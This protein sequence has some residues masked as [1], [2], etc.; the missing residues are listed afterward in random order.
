MPK[1]DL[2]L[3]AEDD[4]KARTIAQNDKVPLRFYKD[5][6][7]SSIW[8]ISAFVAGGVGIAFLIS[9]RVTPT[10]LTTTTIMV[11]KASLEQT[12]DYDIVMIG[13]NLARNY[14]DMITSGD[15]LDQVR[16]LLDSDISSGEL[17]ESI[18]ANHIANTQLIEISVMYS[19]PELTVEIAD[20]LVNVFS[21]QIEK[22]Q[23]EAAASQDNEVK[24]QLQDMEN[25][26]A[27]LQEKL[28]EQSLQLYN[29]RLDSINATLKDLRNQIE[30][31][32]QE[33]AP[34]QTKYALTESERVELLNKET[35]KGEL[36]ALQSRYQNE[37]VT[38]TMQGPTFDSTD[39][40]SSQDYA[41]L[42]RN[43]RTYLSLLQNYQNM[44]VTRIPNMVKVIQVDRPILPERPIRPKLMVNLML[45]F[46][47]GSLLSAIYIFIIKLNK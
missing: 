5:L 1:G 24:I 47:A 32:N 38:L 46:V 21:S 19:D 8:I 44:K 27:R 2:N 17:R 37:L 29:Q 10:Y 39:L 31:I 3:H 20:S 12:S 26:I 18:T 41:L 15:V 42:D 25:E 34:L 35:H 7:L 33:M 9:I 43:Q 40:L 23:L 45:G 11:S 6:L 28:K 13:V 16:P 30:Q 14:A 36:S 22:T 4:M